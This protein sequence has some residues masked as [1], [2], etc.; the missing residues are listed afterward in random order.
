MDG[1]DD[2]VPLDLAC[3]MQLGGGFWVILT[4][5]GEWDPFL[6]RIMACSN[7]WLEPVMATHVGVVSSPRASIL[8]P[9]LPWL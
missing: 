3:Q 7:L 5:V 2:L 1:V 8:R 9:A 4:F 6:L